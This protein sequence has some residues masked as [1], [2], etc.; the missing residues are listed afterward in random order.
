MAVSRL[1]EVAYIT[2]AMTDLAHEIERQ[3]ER[4][5]V[6]LHSP[7]GWQAILG[8]EFGE[9]ARE[10]TAFM[11]PRGREPN[12]R[13]YRKELLQV[14]AVAVRTAIALDKGQVLGINPNIHG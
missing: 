6:I 4:F 8:E 14:A 11:P 9:V 10:V 1:P 5:G 3:E 2:I 7:E 13:N 12:S